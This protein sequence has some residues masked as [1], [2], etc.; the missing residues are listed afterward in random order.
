MD[1]L[2]SVQSRSLPCATLRLGRMLRYN[3]F[4]QA[5]GWLSYKQSNRCG[6]QGALHVGTQ[7]TAARWKEMLVNGN[8]ARSARTGWVITAAVIGFLAAALVYGLSGQGRSEGRTAPDFTLTTFSGAKISLDE[9]RGQVVV[10]NFWA[11]WCAP[12]REEAPA[13][14]RT[15]RR[16][17]GKGVSFIGV[18]VSDLDKNALAFIERFSISYPNAPDRLGRVARAYRITGQPETFIIAAGGQLMAQHLGA[19]SEE[20]LQA[21]IEPHLPGESGP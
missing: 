5:D 15:W 14:E 18:N 17:Q 11:S 1:M 19:I 16:Y 21:L 6:G 12:C 2:R 4:V 20:Q 9:Q 3:M 10:L 8:T 7:A 13:L